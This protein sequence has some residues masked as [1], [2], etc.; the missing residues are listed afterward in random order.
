MRT[1]SMPRAPGA[2]FHMLRV[3]LSQLS[4]SPRTRDGPIYVHR[5][6]APPLEILRI[7]DLGHLRVQALASVCRDSPT[8]ER[9]HH[10]P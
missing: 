8:Q 7:G 10:R 4:V 2:S 5:Q 3:L 1:L 9:W 6:Q